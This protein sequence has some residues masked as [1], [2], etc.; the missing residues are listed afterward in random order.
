MNT[1]RLA[2]TET[3]AVLEPG[4]NFVRL[5]WPVSPNAAD[6]GGFKIRYSDNV[7][8]WATIE[9]P[10]GI[11]F[12]DGIAEWLDDGSETG[13]GP[14]PGGRFYQLELGR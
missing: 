2:T 13:G 12:V 9:D 5:R 7:T 14:A 10:S 3:E 1:L 8:D 6:K 4:A 11:V